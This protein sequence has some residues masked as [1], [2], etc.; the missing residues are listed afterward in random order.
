MMYCNNCQG[1]VGSVSENCLAFLLKWFHPDTSAHLAGQFNICRDDF[2]LFMTILWDVHIFPCTHHKPVH[3]VM[4]QGVKVPLATQIQP[5]Q[6]LLFCICQLLPFSNSF[7]CKSLK[8]HV[9]PW[10]F[11]PACHS[12]FKHTKEDLVC[13]HYHNNHHLGELKA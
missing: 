2:L 1:T 3:S 10:E 11:W 13:M 5:R 4:T 8:A 7:P 12:R 6:M 9:K